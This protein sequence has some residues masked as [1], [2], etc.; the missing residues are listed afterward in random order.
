M[1]SWQ[2]EGCSWLD[3]ETLLVGSEQGDLYRIPL[4]ELQ[5]TK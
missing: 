1:L 2:I 3:R 4:K 5:E